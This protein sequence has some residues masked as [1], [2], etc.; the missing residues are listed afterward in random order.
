MKNL[1]SSPSRAALVLGF[2]VLLALPLLYAAPADARGRSGHRGHRVGGAVV[3]RAPI[4]F[5]FGYYPYAYG[6]PYG[7][8]AGGP[9]LYRQPEGGINPQIARLQGWGGID[10]N[11]KP[12]KAEVWVDGQYMG[13]VGEYD[14]YPY[15]LWLPE[16]DHSV[17]VYRGGYESWER[18]VSI[19]AGEVIKVKQKLEKGGSSLPPGNR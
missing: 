16:G 15:Y 17:T 2:V 9:Y 19:R 11:I 13:T 8:Y 3:L 12:K 10:L 18:D 6:Y 4:G 5:G 1:S 7:Y 14:G